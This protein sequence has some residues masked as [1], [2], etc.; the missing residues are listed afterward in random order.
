[1]QIQGNL[2][3]N[4]SCLGGDLMQI[5]LLP[6]HF[7]TTHFQS[8]NLC[9]FV[10]GW[11]FQRS[12]GKERTKRPHSTQLFWPINVLVMGLG[13]TMLFCLQLLFYVIQETCMMVVNKRGL[14]AGPKPVRGKKR[15]INLKVSTSSSW[16]AMGW[17]RA[18]PELYLF[19]L[20]TAFLTSWEKKKSYTSQFSNSS[21]SLPMSPGLFLLCWARNSAFPFLVFGAY[22]KKM[23][24]ILG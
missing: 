5:V 23:T 21:S 6:D 24:V 9:V 4:N 1:M 2:I 20:K 13:T 11:A 22:R 3:G 15:P 14:G 10:Q 19:S 8:Q 7:P 16:L 18:L 12:I 17:F